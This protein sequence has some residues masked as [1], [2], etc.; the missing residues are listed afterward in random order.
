MLHMWKTRFLL[1]GMMKYELNLLFQEGSFLV[2]VH[3]NMPRLF[4]EVR[5]I[6]WI[7]GIP[8]ARADELLLVRGFTVHFQP[9]LLGLLKIS[10]GA[11]IF[12]ESPRLNT[13]KY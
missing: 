11:T 5:C 4:Y 3:R 12:L 1:I 9:M 10:T 6:S 8:T 7:L 2:P 13:L